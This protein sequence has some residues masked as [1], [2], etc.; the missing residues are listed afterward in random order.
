[1]QNFYYSV[2]LPT[3]LR[4]LFTYH[5]STKIAPGSRVAVSFNRRNLV[6]FIIKS[7]PKPNF[8]TIRGETQTEVW[9][10]KAKP[11]L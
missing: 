4:Q 2:A 3:P 5:S 10:K 6:G 1:M 9:C 8:K 11:K 7:C